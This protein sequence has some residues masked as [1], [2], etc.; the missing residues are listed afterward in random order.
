MDRAIR[1]GSSK[2]IGDCNIRQV[3]PH[4][5]HITNWR[6]SD[7]ENFSDHRTIAFYI[8]DAT[9]KRREQVRL[10]A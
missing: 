3:K 6:V 7:E 1:P 10:E 4:L 8:S 5:W 9:A 2:R